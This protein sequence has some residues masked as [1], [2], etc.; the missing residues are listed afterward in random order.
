MET[1]GGLGKRFTVKQKYCRKGPHN[2]SEQYLR[3]NIT[4]YKIGVWVLGKGIILLHLILREINFLWE[5]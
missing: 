5:S 4:Y 3:F 1:Y 2:K